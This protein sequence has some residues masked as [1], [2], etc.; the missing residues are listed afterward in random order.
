MSQIDYAVASALII[1]V[2]FFSIFFTSSS[3]SSEINMLR[4]NELKESASS[5]SRQLLE[6][7]LISNSKQVKVILEEVGGYEHREQI[8][9]S[10]EP[11]VQKPHV[12]DEFFNEIPSTKK[13]AGNKIIISFWS[14]FKPYEKK[15]VKILFFGNSQILDYLSGGID[16]NARILSE[17]KINVISQDK[18]LY[19]KN[20]DY[21]EIKDL[22]GFEHQFKINISDCVF[23]LNPPEANVIIKSIPVL[24]EKSDEI[25]Y[26]EYSKV[27]VW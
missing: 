6:N 26:P 5:L 20:L 11:I 2:I 25:I 8:K 14:D 9:I 22:L 18:C 1:T 10:I 16:V 4:V 27:I 12:Y 3:Y 13:I 19:F 7:D 23:G 21:S 17:Q 24:I 15:R